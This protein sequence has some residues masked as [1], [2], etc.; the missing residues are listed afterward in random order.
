MAGCDSLIDR[1][2]NSWK[3]IDNNICAYDIPASL[4][5]GQ[6]NKYTSSCTIIY[7]LVDPIIYVKN[8]ST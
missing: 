1:S 4:R 8:E 6:F 5:A 7:S 2:A 3:Y